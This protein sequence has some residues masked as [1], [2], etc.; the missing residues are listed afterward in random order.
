M[1]VV[2]WLNG[3]FG[4]GK[5]TVSEH[6]VMR[7]PEALVFDA[8][9]PG[10]MLREIV[11]SPPEDFQDLRVWR[12]S[13]VDTAA[14]LLAEYQRPLLVPMT[15]VNMGYLREIFDGL[16][17][18]GANVRH[19]F[20][21]VPPQTLRRRIQEQVIW[22]D[23]VVRDAEV[24]RWRLEQVERCARAAEVL[25]EDA[26][27]LDGERSPTELAERVLTGMTAVTA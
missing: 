12:R 4:A 25:P 15:V 10:F 5:T 26:V 14:M 3:S 22:P 9:L 7:W 20:L 6:L 23:D 17:A 27:V 16:G 1:S 11:P 21:D 18:A 2:C 8:E 13:A 24:R 19:F